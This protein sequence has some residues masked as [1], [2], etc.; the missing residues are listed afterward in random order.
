MQ[1]L[2][3]DSIMWLNNLSNQ[4][5]CSELD[6]IVDLIKDNLSDEEY[7]KLQVLINYFNS[8]E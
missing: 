1:I 7:D 4:E 5:W 6:K 8:I 3:L 2:V